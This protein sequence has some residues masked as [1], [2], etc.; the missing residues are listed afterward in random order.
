[1]PA[2]EWCDGLAR[3]GRYRPP[4]ARL[5]SGAADVGR[6]SPEGSRHGSGQGRD[7]DQTVTHEELPCSCCRRTAGTLHDRDESSV[8]GRCPGCGGALHLNRGSPE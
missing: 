6:D 5:A 2:R 7:G 8:P 1:M 4:L 3:G